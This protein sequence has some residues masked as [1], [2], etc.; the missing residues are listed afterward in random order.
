MYNCEKKIHLKIYRKK[1]D[2]DIKEWQRKCKTPNTPDKTQNSSYQRNDS[3]IKKYF[4]ALQI[5]MKKIKVR[6]NI[7]NKV[8][9][10]IEKK[11]IR[12]NSGKSIYRF[13]K[14]VQIVLKTVYDFRI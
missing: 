10:N 7:E 1:I 6:E 9:E 2:Y 13:Q 12:Q 3:D 14:G 5:K 8:R 11:C 4:I